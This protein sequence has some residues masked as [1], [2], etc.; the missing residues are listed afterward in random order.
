M[1][2]LI[3]RCTGPTA[4]KEADQLDEELCTDVGSI[5]AL[6]KRF[7]SDPDQGGYYPTKRYDLQVP[8]KAGIIPGVI[9]DITCSKLGL[10][11]QKMIVRSV[12]LN[13]TNDQIWANI[14]AEYYD[15][16]YFTTSTSTT[17][18][19]TTTTTTV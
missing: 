14:T 11:N 3:R 17:L 18:T 15:V 6:G 13:G 1:S 19:P 10:T 7:L 2:V 9:I 16:T 12:Q 8:Y 5:K 4:N